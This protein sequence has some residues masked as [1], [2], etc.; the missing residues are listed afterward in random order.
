EQI[1][2]DF[3]TNAEIPEIVDCDYALTNGLNIQIDSGRI[4]RYGLQYEVAGQTVTLSPAANQ[5]RIDLIIATLSNNVTA[6]L[7]FLAFQRLRSEQEFINTL[8]PY[9]PT[10]FQRATEKHN[11]APISVKTGIPSANPAPPVLGVNE[12]LLYSVT[13]PADA[14]SLEN[15]DVLDSRKTASNISGINESIASLLARLT[16]VEDKILV[17]KYRYPSILTGDG[18]IPFN[19]TDNNGTWVVDIP[20]GID[21]QFGDGFVRIKAENFQDSSVNAQYVN[22]SNGGVQYLPLVEPT[23]APTANATSGNEIRFNVPATTKTLY[24]NR[25][26][27]LFF[28]DAAQ[29]S[30]PTECI[31]MQ[32]IRSG[33][34]P[35]T[36]KTYRNLR[37]SIADYSKTKLAGNAGTGQFELDLGVPVGV[38]YGNAY[39]VRASN[40]DVYNIPVPLV[41]FDSTITVTNVT[42]GDK[43]FVRLFVL[44]AL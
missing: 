3:L 18:K 28:R 33:S 43:W 26:G 5:A 40:N 27:E 8:P 24:L 23:G 32:S 30:N 20:V 38:L 12:V 29:P 2:L 39:A 41:N 7:E 6:N 31:L 22:I 37:N 36:V 35:P 25:E 11:L 13:V 21:V 19:L 4:Y 17:L 14:V 1:T 34:N 10:Q 42:D 44:S 15:S 16:A 9:P